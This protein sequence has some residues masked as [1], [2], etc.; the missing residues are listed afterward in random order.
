MSFGQRLRGLRRDFDLSQAEL[1]VRAGCSA[2]TVRKLESDER[3]PSRDLAARLAAVFELPPRDRTEFLREARGTHLATRPALPTP[4]TRLIGREA[5]L[6]AVRDRIL[7]SD[8][9]LLTLMGPPGVGKTRLALQ[10]ATDLQEAFRDGAVFVQLAATQDPARVLDLVA[11]ALGVR[12]AAAR[13]IGEAVAEHLA[14]Q[15]VLLVLDNFE[16]VILAAH[17]LP[18]LLAGAARLKIFVTSREPLGVYGEHLF[19]VPTLGL[20]SASQ[21]GARSPSETLFLERAQALRSGFGARPADAA[22]VAEICTRLEGLPLAIELAASRARSMSPT[23]MLA[24]LGKQLDLLSSGPTDF[25]LRQRSMRGALDWSYALM[26][27]AERQLF[28]Q[29]TVFAGGATLEAITAVCDTEATTV[30]ALVDK[31]VLTRQDERFGM[32]EVIREYAAEKWCDSAT[33]GVRETVT[34]R[35][36]EYFAA[37][38]D[39]APSALRGAEQLRWLEQLDAEHDNLRA[40]LKWALTHRDAG[41]AGRLGAGLWPFWR[42]RGLYHEGRRWL[43]A[44]LA[45]GD[46]VPALLRAHILNGA[47]VLALLQTDYAAASDLLEQARATFV[48]LNDRFGEAFA[49]SNLG[50]LARN[51]ADVATA[52]ALFEASLKLRREIGDRWGEAWTLINLAVVAQD[53][54][55]FA[56]TRTLLSESVELFRKVGDRSGSLQALH[57]LGCALLELRDYAEARMLLTE[58]LT[59]ARAL[60]DARGVANSLGDLALVSLYTGDYATAAE[61]FEDSLLAYAR[62]GDRRNVAACIEGLAGVAAVTGR[63]LDA[64]RQF[65]LAA[66]LRESV[67]AP[68]LATDRDRYDSTLAAAREQ[69]DEQTWQRAWAEGQAATPEQLL[70]ELLG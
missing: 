25:T 64:A 44:I 58:S 59:L 39:A 49:T 10:A 20:P 26:D 37:M 40:A 30:D 62:L 33:E 70:P 43:D 46:A 68:L 17:E 34:A 54:S 3:K 50:W 5:D 36:A 19:S 53:R 4:M 48:A 22:V 51:R 38:A 23:T 11:Q 21:R 1:G 35:H 2:N 14:Q 7:R 12:A 13:P 32:L 24:E 66:S 63:A 67:G 31:S 61:Q 6:R 56:A 8:V 65:G 16:Q 45:L 29:F 57:N 28:G 42:A 60:D 27:V 47:G 9:R 52:Q 55:D 41:L 18:P 69:L 15:Q